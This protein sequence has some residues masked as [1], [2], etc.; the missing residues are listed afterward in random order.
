M[1][2]RGGSRVVQ[3]KQVLPNWWPLY[4]SIR[5]HFTIQVTAAGGVG[6]DVAE[7]DG[8][9]QGEVL[10]GHEDSQKEH[11]EGCDE[12]FATILESDHRQ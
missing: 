9:A 6:E 12:P 4:A 3:F 10:A 7:F 11:R 5:G 1:N 2:G 8:A